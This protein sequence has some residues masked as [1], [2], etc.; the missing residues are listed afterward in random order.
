MIAVDQQTGSKDLTAPLEALGLPIV[1]TMLKSADLSFEGRGIGGTPVNIGIEHKTMEDLVQAIRTGRLVGTQLPKMLGPKGAYDHG[2]LIAEGQ[3]R[4]NRKTGA[5]QLL[6]RPKRRRFGPP[7]AEWADARGRMSGAEFEKH[8]FTL[9]IVGGLH[10][11]FA[12]DRQASLQF[13]ANLY[14]WWTD[15]NLDQHSSHVGQHTPHGFLPLSDFRDVVSR[16]P[17]VGVRTSAFVEAHFDGNLLQACCAS[18]KDWAEVTIKD[19]KGGSRRLGLK[20]GTDIAA[21]M[22]G[23]KP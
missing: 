3:W 12:R 15:K 21:F 5:L 20:A 6:G 2:W 4:I 8:L 19:Q 22:R 1:A 10:V 13:I 9:E 11:H 17:H 7:S 18:A 23:K 14:Y 16:F